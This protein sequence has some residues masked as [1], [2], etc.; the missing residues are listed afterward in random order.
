MLISYWC[1]WQG[2]LL[3][4][5]PILRLAAARA[6]GAS[7]T[8]PLPAPPGNASLGLAVSALGLQ[9]LLIIIQC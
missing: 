8:A 5:I 2:E 4:L 3:P 7:R 6:E 1:C 9:V